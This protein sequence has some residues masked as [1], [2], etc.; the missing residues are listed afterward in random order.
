VCLGLTG[1]KVVQEAAREM[2]AALAREGQP[3]VRFLVQKMAPSGMEMGGRQR[4]EL[5]TCSRL[6]RRRGR[7]RA[8]EGHS[9][10]HHAPDRGGCRGDA[11][12][13]GDLSPARRIPRSAEGGRG[14]PRAAP[15]SSKPAGG[16]QPGDR[17]DGSQPVIVH[18]NGVAV[19]DSRVRLQTAPPEKLPGTR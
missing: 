10:P 4:S 11:A 16:G 1:R 2:A 7:H 3:E 5:R 14:R 8:P 18:A 12:I 17:G 13:V 6:R 15:A 9:G 19:V